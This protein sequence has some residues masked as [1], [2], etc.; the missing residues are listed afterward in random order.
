VRFHSEQELFSDVVTGPHPL[1]FKSANIVD[2]IGDVRT[3]E[4]SCI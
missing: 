1:T 3:R 4:L 2:S